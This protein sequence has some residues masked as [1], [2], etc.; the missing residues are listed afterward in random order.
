MIQTSVCLVCFFPF[1]P[2]FD[3]FLAEFSTLPEQQDQLQLGVRDA[4]VS[5]LYLWKHDWW[6]WTSWSV[7]K[8]EKRSA[9]QPDAGKFDRVLSGALPRE[10][11][12][13]SIAV[14]SITLSPCTHTVCSAGLGFQSARRVLLQRCSLC[15]PYKGVLVLGFFSLINS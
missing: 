7:Y 11:G 10:P 4:A 13:T 14:T 5:G 2:G 8:W 12:N 3:T 9:D 6:T 1:P 15:L